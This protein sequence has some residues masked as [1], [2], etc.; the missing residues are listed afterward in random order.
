MVARATLA[1]ATRVAKASC[2]HSIFG[3][4]VPDYSRITVETM[5]IGQYKSMILAS[6]Y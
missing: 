6:A 2:S 1:L 5:F 4:N 3:I